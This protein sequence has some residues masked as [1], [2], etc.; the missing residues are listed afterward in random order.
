MLV[1]PTL[2]IPRRY[3]W[4]DPRGLLLVVLVLGALS[5][6]TLGESSDSEVHVFRSLPAHSVL[7][8]HGAEGSGGGHPL[9]CQL[10]NGD[11]F[12]AFQAWDGSWDESSWRVM[13]AR[14]TDDGRHWSNPEVLVDSPDNEGNIALGVLHD[15]TLLLGYEIFGNEKGEDGKPR[16]PYI[17]YNVIRSTDHGKNW[18]T[19]VEIPV[20]PPWKLASYSRI[21]QL[22]DQTLLLPLYRYLQTEDPS[23]ERHPVQ[24]QG[25]GPKLGRCKSDRG[26]FQRNQRGPVEFRKTA[27]SHAGNAE[28]AGSD[29]PGSF[30]RQG[31]HLEP[32]TICHR[33]Q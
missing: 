30:H 10:T 5:F 24:I 18:S 14:S 6:Q 2:K 25:W 33:S 16:F 31:L 3:S 4:L 17:S 22:P 8:D 19:Q 26:S 29:R 28:T 7:I 23:Q 12:L 32:A 15:G 13:T 9:A 1:D 20:E 11:I 21:I 27:G